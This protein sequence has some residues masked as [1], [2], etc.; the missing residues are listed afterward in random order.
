[1]IDDHKVLLPVLRLSLPELRSWVRLVWIERSL[2]VLALQTSATVV[3]VA[4]DQ[5]T[6]SPSAVEAPPAIRHCEFR[7]W[8]LTNASWPFSLKNL[9]VNI[10]NV[11]LSSRAWGHSRAGPTSGRESRTFDSVTS[12]KS[13]LFVQSKARCASRPRERNQQQSFRLET[14]MIMTI[15]ISFWCEFQPVGVVWFGWRFVSETGCVF[16]RPP[17]PI[18]L[19]LLLLL[20]LR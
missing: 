14:E 13:N 11:L 20:L 17:V 18:L 10:L 15:I 4:P 3:V 16:E 12:S 8:Q 7:H 6:G 2:L 9:N 19:I 1:M 5:T